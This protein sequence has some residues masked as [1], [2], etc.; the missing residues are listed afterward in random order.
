MQENMGTQVCARVPTPQS[1]RWEVTVSAMASG[2][3]ATEHRL[4]V[5][6]QVPSLLPLLSAASQKFPLGRCVLGPK[7]TRQG[8]PGLLGE[9]VQP[10]AGQETPKV[11]GT[12]GAPT[13]GT[14]GRG[15]WESS[16]RPKPG[17]RGPTK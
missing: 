13:L 3:G 6:S 16:R 10:A 17:T 9:P 12:P 14:T 1:C 5:P 7:A 11:T 4:G 15:N 8:T 2:V